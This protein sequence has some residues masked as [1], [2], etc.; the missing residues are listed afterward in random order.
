[1]TKSKD[2]GVGQPK[3]GYFCRGF[4]KRKVIDAFFYL[5]AEQHNHYF[6]DGTA[7]PPR[8][9]REI[10]ADVIFRPDSISGCVYFDSVVCV[11]DGD[12]W[13]VCTYISDII[14]VAA[15]VGGCRTVKISGACCCRR[16]RNPNGVDARAHPPRYR[17]INRRRRLN[18]LGGASRKVACP[19]G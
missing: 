18:S 3:G 10:D 13:R 4:T 5:P 7:A 8:V 12:I 2:F 1:V 6:C 19:A 16:M 11:L 14:T 9:G 15:Y 17:V